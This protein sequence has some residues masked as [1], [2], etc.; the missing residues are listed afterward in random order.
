MGFLKNVVS[1]M[2]VFWK[3]PY[4]KN[5]YLTKN[6]KKKYIFRGFIENAY[7][8]YYIYYIFHS[9]NARNT[10][11][12]RKK[13]VVSTFLYLLH[14]TTNLL[15]YPTTTYYIFSKKGVFWVLLTTRNSFF[16]VSASYKELLP[17]PCAYAYHIPILW[18]LSRPVR[19]YILIILNVVP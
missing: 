7:Y 17:L 2:P 4:S 1:K 18:E 10:D 15:H 8:T 5:F 9:P 11:K 19:P 14:L 12:Q 13:G 6:R 3:T 16:A